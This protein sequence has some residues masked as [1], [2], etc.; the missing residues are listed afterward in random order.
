MLTISLFPNPNPNPNA[1]ILNSFT[2][3]HFHTPG[4]MAQNG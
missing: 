4:K 3:A 2:E 1:K